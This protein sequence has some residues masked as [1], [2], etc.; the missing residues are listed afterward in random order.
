MPRL[1][2][3]YH[4]AIP[5]RKTLFYL[6]ALVF[7]VAGCAC[8]KCCTVQTAPPTSTRAQNRMNRIIS[9]NLRDRFNLALLR[10]KSMWVDKTISFLTL[11]HH[12]IPDPRSAE[13][14]K[15][16]YLEICE[17]TGHIHIHSEHWISTT[18]AALALPW[19]NFTV[20]WEGAFKS[21]RSRR[22]DKRV[23][24]KAGARMDIRN[25]ILPPVTKKV[26]TEENEGLRSVWWGT[27]WRK[28][29]IITMATTPAIAAGRL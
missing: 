15:A 16:F 6:I 2:H 29:N 27:G 21:S 7:Y 3:D 11:Y 1:K 14:L 19:F 8:I 9:T 4:T 18:Q 20:S 12:N 26:A 24:V 22:P 5:L 13:K 10:E 28:S 23:P 25:N 17:Q